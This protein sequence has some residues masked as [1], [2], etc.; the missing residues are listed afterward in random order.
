[1]SKKLGGAFLVLVTPLDEDNKQDNESLSKLVGYYLKAGVSGFTILGESSEIDKLS[2]KEKE[3]NLA[4]VKER[5]RGKVP[6]VFGTSQEGTQKAVEESVWAEQQGAD[7][8]M[9]APPK[10][11]KLRDDA[12]FNYY[13]E[14]N[15]KINIPI[16]V[17]DYPQT[18]HPYMSPNL[19]SRINSELSQAQYLKLEDP[20]TPI[21][22][23]KVKELVGENMK[24]FSALG[25]KSYLWD[26][27]RGAIGVMTASPTPEY[28]VGIWN[29]HQDNDREKAL[30][31]FW[32]YLP[33]I[34]FYEEGYGISVRKHVLQMRGI[35]KTAN[36]KIPG[37]ELDNKGKKELA[38]LLKW[39]ETE[40]QNK[41]G[42]F[43]MR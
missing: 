25:A 4:I 10:N 36:M 5:V 17:Q 19:I 33:L 37:P 35:I 26:L 30:E 6:L 32:R 8:L 27:D 7:G 41:T 42:L 22:L 40:I 3:D 29:A 34:H 13:A 39:V 23:T 14:I 12:I 15:D 21:K 38:E 16:I 2:Q 18:N 28:L 31:I 1:M 9:I 11:I 24:I 20:P 43:P